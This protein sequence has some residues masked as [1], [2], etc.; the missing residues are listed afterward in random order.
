MKNINRKIISGILSVLMLPQI[1]L[2]FPSDL[3]DVPIKDISDEISTA[4]VYSNEKV[5]ETFKIL[6]HIGT[7]PEEESEFEEDE[8]VT[9]AYAASAFA[10]LAS[11]RKPK[12][13]SDIYRC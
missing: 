4:G 8:I 11:G 6:K 5:H 13:Y 1:G 7:I 3:D 12:R 9:R 2:A 10:A